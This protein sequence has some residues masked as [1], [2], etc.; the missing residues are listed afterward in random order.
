M[1]IKVKQVPS[2]EASLISSDDDCVLF[3]AD[4]ITKSLEAFLVSH[5][6][7]LRRGEWT[8]DSACSFHITPHKEWFYTYRPLD[9][10]VVTMGNEYTCKVAGIGCIKIQM[11]DGIIRTQSNVRHVPNMKRNLIS[12]ATLENDGYENAC[13]NGT[14]KIN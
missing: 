10:G 6:N 14:F 1:L 8:L 12:L 7:T 3:V 13:K 5:D 2:G 4:Q 9:H 11:H